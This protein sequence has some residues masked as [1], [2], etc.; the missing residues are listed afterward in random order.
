MT[1]ANGN[2]ITEQDP[3]VGTS[4]NPKVYYGV[5]IDQYPYYKYTLISDMKKIVACANAN[6]GA[7]KD[8][9]FT[10]VRATT[11][12]EREKNITFQDDQYWYWTV[13]ENGNTAKN[14]ISIV[15]QRQPVSYEDIREIPTTLL[16]YNYYYKV[17][18]AYFCCK[19]SAGSEDSS[20]GTGEQL[21]YRY[22][23]WY[24]PSYPQNQDVYIPVVE[25]DGKTATHYISDAEYKLTPG[26]GNYDFVPDDTAPEQTVEV[27][28]M[29]YQGGIYKP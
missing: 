3:A 29:Y 16:E 7:V 20:A 6:A 8:G 21:P 4:A 10:P 17:S 18:Q 19:K 23:G 27:D 14:P 1:D 25:N 13:D 15:T 11:S 2:K 9:T 28:H 22:F 12:E 24:V 26:T 5:T